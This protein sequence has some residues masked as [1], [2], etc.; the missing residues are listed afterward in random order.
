MTDARKSE[1]AV[2]KIQEIQKTKA[3]YQSN[4][5]RIEH[6]KG[7]RIRYFDQQ[8]RNEQD[9]IK[10]CDRQIEDLKRQI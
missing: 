10:Q 8:I 5:A 7:D 1:E 9:R 2:K 3:N 6:E 4:I